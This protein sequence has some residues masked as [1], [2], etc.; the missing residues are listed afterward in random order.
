MKSYY[1]FLETGLLEKLGE[2][3]KH[4]PQ[5]KIEEQIQERIKSAAERSR[6]LA[7]SELVLKMILKGMDFKDIAELSGLSIEEIEQLKNEN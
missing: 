1:S 5:Y 4:V 6:I 2:S 3:L 7:Q